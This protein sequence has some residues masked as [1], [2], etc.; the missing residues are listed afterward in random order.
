MGY[1]ID[2]QEIE[3]QVQCIE[4]IAQGCVLYNSAF[5]EITVFYEA[6]SANVTP[7]GIRRTLATVFPK[8]MIPTA[9]HSMASLPKNPNGK[10]DRNGLTKMLSASR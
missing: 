4:G 1:R 5:K 10:V 9:F 2:L 3:H 8:Y 6:L 7:A